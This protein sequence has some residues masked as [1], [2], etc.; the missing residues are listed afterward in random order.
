MKQYPKKDS[1]NPCPDL[2]QA[3]QSYNLY[4][5]SIAR[6]KCKVMDAGE[7]KG[8]LGEG[9]NERMLLSKARQIDTSVSRW[10]MSNDPIERRDIVQNVE[11][12]IKSVNADVSSQGVYTTE[13][14]QAL[15]VFR[16]AERYFKNN[17]NR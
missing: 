16:E 14:R 7:V 15:S 4:A 12:I 17:C 13:Q 6:M 10:L 5:D 11:A 2:K 8:M 3:L 9:V 1:E